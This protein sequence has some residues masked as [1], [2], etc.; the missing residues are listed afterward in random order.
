[1]AFSDE[2]KFRIMF[3]LCHEG[4]ILIEG[5]T[6]YSKIIA[7][8]LENLNS[9][10]EDRALTLVES[11]ET[12]KGKLETGS[13]KD[14]VKQIGDIHLDTDKNRSLKQ[15]ELKRLLDELSKLLDIPNRCR[16]GGG[17]MGCLVL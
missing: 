6:S 11:I 3:A 12:M 15:K 2:D 13:L 17:G 9:F 7:D 5:S 8:R 14:N 1:M 16:V 4:K 10:I